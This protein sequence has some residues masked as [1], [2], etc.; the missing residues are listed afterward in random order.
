MRLLVGLGNP[1]RE[2]DDTRHN[3]GFLVVDK[4]ADRVGASVDDKKFRARVGRGRIGQESTLIMKPQTYMNLSGESVGPALGFFKL[5]TDDVVVVHDELDL[6]LGRLKL[7]R[8]GGHG[9]HNGL[10]SL[11]KHLP[12]DRFIRI[13][14]GIGRPPP[15]WDTADYVLSKFRSDE[16]TAV[17]E[18]V[19]T[20][21]D[22]VEAIFRDGISKAM[23]TFNRDTDK[24]ANDAKKKRAD[25]PEATTAPRSA[26]AR[27]PE[28]ARPPK[29]EEKS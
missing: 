29:R 9:G 28:G 4:V 26:E 10:R 21:A 7:K 5:S 15:Q 13:R 11:I 1:G 16:W 25:R 12:D 8:G 2:Y 24:G 27:E 22:A 14:I 18:A 3:V 6:P 23:A 20:A 17:D 19:S